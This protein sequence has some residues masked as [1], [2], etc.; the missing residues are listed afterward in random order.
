MLQ[1]DGRRI[2]PLPPR[3][4]CPHEMTNY[5]RLP[6]SQFPKTTFSLGENCPLSN[7][8]AP[9]Q[10]PSWNFFP[11][12]GKKCPCPHITMLSSRIGNVLDSIFCHCIAECISLRATITLLLFNIININ[13]LLLLLTNIIH[14]LHNNHSNQIIIC[15]AILHKQ[16]CP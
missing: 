10:V 4:N 9:A 3:G 16:N 15:K 6:A 13:L 7:S 5:C 8:S 14:I 1:V 11:T 12:R 2:H